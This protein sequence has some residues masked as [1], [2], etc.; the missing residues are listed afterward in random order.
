MYSKLK[1]LSLQL[2]LLATVQ[3]AL[4]KKAQ[5]SSLRSHKGEPSSEKLSQSYVQNY[6]VNQFL[7]NT[8][9]SCN[10]EL[11]SCTYDSNH[12]CWNLLNSTEI[13]L[14]QYSNY[15]DYG[16]YIAN[17]TTT[18]G[19]ASEYFSYCIQ[20]AI[21]NFNNSLYGHNYYFINLYECWA[22]TAANASAPA[23]PIPTWTIN[24]YLYY[25]YSNCVNE[26]YNCTNSYNCSSL[27]NKTEEELSYMSNY[28][29]AC[30][31]Y[32]PWVNSTFFFDE[33]VSRAPSVNEYSFDRN[34]RNLN[35][36]WN[37]TANSNSS[38]SSS[39]STRFNQSNI[40]VYRKLNQTYPDCQ[41]ELNACTFNNSCAFQLNI[42]E[43]YLSYFAT[44]GYGCYLDYDNSTYAE[45]YFNNCID[46]TRSNVT[47]YSYQYENLF[48]CWYTTARNTN[49]STESMQ[50]Y[51]FLRDTYPNCSYNLRHCLDEDTCSFNLNQTELLLQYYSNEG[52]YGCA[53]YN[54]TSGN[55][56]EYYYWCLSRTYSNSSLYSYAY[57]DLQD[58]WNTYSNYENATN[59]SSIF[60]WSAGNFLYNSFYE[61]D[62]QYYNCVYDYECSGIL[63]QTQDQLAN[64]GNSYWACNFLLYSNFTTPNNYY[65]YCINETIANYAYWNTNYNYLRNCWESVA[66]GNSSNSTNSSSID[67]SEV[68]YWLQS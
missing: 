65:Q 54:A 46:R 45:Y 36:C 43:N 8:Y 14:A 3:V 59:S 10:S 57:R 25:N 9:P 56:T 30:D 42:T 39:N 19:N 12:T 55:A 2:L 5:G 20:R 60:P 51:S 37:A 15:G 18:G 29:F 4:S 7:S 23:Y 41:S 32:S 63:N 22:Q 53:L 33:C 1:K 27:L 44:H 21:P 48:N 61:C 13:T 17:Q 38:S 40:A 68:N 28:M 6:E 11:W 34:W 50:V 35:R 47:V 26:W 24:N 16:C 62:S 64:L 49:I 58:C 52:Y 67:S 66:F 31:V